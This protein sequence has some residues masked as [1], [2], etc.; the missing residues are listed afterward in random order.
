MNSRYIGN[1]KDILLVEQSRQTK[2][3]QTKEPT[4]TKEIKEIKKIKFKYL[5]GADG[6]L[7]R[8]AKSNNLFKKNQRHFWNGIQARVKIKNDN[9]VEFY[10]Y[11]G[12]YAWLIPEDE[13]TARIGLVS[14]RY[15]K[16][17]FRNFLF[18]FKQIKNKDIIEYQAGV[19]P[20]YNPNI[21]TQKT[22][23]KSA[24]KSTIY[25]VG[26]SASQVKATTGGGIVQGLSAAKALADTIIHNEYN[27]TKT[28]QPQKQNNLRN[29]HIY[30]NNYICKNNYK[31]DY[32]NAW[33]KSIG[34]ELYLH[35]K[36]R[37]M[38]DKF[39]N[40]DWNR[41]VDIMN[42]KECKEVLANNNRDNLSTTLFRLILKKPSLLSFARRIL[43]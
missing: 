37:N 30:Q 26:D 13:E 32:Q 17:L 9:A 40:K 29:N 27:E 21:S 23:S 16:I 28:K 24:I 20:K 12:T 8:V 10:P 33:K 43:Y 39:Q 42:S 18:K 38:M 1:K 3:I 4:Q 19:I 25:I 5:I 36:A 31:Y 7:S 15:T 2:K 6:P 35:L 14:K 11:F 22:S 34:K 41:L